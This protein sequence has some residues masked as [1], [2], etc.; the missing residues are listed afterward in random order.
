MRLMF[1]VLIMLVVHILLRLLKLLRPLKLRGLR[2]LLRLPN[3]VLRLDRRYCFLP[4]VV[5]REVKDVL[6]V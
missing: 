4:T 2:S 5:L 3:S 1:V 6:L